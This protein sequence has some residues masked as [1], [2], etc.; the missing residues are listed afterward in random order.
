[1]SKKNTAVVIEPTPEQV[2][3]WILFTLRDTIATSA[4][5]HIILKKFLT[6]IEG[7]S[8]GKD[9]NTPKEWA[10]YEADLTKVLGESGIVLFTASNFPDDTTGETHF[11]TYLVNPSKKTLLMIDPARKPSG[12]SGIYAAAASEKRIKPFFEKNEYSVDWILTESTCQSSSQDIFCQTWSLYLLIE[13]FNTLLGDEPRPKLPIPRNQMGRYALL[14]DFFKKCV[15][16]P[17]V[18]DAFKKEW[19]AFTANPNNVIYYDLKTAAQK[20]ARKAAYAAI[21]PCA[22]LLAM[23]P[24]LM[25]P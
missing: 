4:V 20:K 9:F 7:V 14:L 17:E 22:F 23:T 5:R 25:K 12:A 16:I 6:S 19:A 24:D 10:T 11:Q 18:C 2:S 21:D 1:M 15:A 8:F 13:T 3:S